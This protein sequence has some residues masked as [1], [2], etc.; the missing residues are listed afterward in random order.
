MAF[1]YSLAQY[2][3]HKT[4][5]AQ[6]YTPQKHYRLPHPG[7]GI[8]GTAPAIYAS[9]H[10]TLPSAFSIMPPQDP[11][12][13][14]DTVSRKLHELDGI[15]CK[16][17][18]VH[19]FPNIESVTLIRLLSEFNFPISKVTPWTLESSVS[20]KCLNA[21]CIRNMYVGDED[22]KLLGSTRGKDIRILK[23]KGGS[24]NG[25]SKSGLMH[26]AKYCNQLRT[27][28]F[29]DNSINR[30]DLC[31]NWLRELA[32]HNK[33]IESLHFN[34]GFDRYD[35]NALT[36]LAKNCSKTLV[37][38]KIGRCS[39]SKLGE[40]FRHAVRLEDFDGA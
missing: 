14:M 23:I 1:T 36:L 34:I 29:K 12:W 28:C 25:V 27:F 21:L 24:Q 37:S 10:T 20:F 39:L 38:L 3:A 30:V 32:L 31:G 33:V 18:T 8:L 5:V 15:T 11:T 19:V 9:Q 6:Q 40:A 17:V 7:Q 35:G 2:V 16:H 26:V 22:I 13:H 4:N